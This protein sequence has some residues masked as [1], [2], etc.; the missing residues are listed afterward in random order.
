MNILV[1]FPLF[2]TEN[3]HKRKD[4]LIYFTLFGLRRYKKGRKHIVSCSCYE[5][6]KRTRFRL[7]LFE[8]ISPHSLYVFVFT[9][10]N[11]HF[12]GL[13]GYMCVFLC[14]GVYA[15]AYFVY[16]YTYFSIYRLRF[17]FILGADVF[18]SQKLF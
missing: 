8:Y 11:K 18:L 17:L 14:V 16:L 9:I 12:V 2:T 4:L 13:Y 5:S 3:S 6:Y 10:E 15:S 7:H 1:D